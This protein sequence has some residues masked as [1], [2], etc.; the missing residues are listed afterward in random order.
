MSILQEKFA[1]VP[2]AR[3]RQGQMYDLTHL[4]LFSVLAIASEATSYRR[5][6]RFI[7]THLVRLC[8]VFGCT[9]RRAPAY[10]T[11]RYA[12]QKLDVADLEACFRQHAADLAANSPDLPNTIALDG[13]TLR[14]SLDRFADQR[15][16]QVLNAL[17]GGDLPLILGHIVL[18][19]VSKDHEIPAV[20][21]LLEEWGLTGRVYTMDALHL[22]KKPLNP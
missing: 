14:G 19:D 12:L 1:G 15:A 11:I 17:T 5:I 6:H 8:E 10:T 7:A 4:L 20:Q 21:R 9:W 13:K 22:Q 3:R 2:D 16:A 18:E